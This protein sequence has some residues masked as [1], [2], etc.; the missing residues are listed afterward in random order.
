MLLQAAQLLLLQAILQLQLM[1][2]GGHFHY[3]ALGS[4]HYC[5]A[6]TGLKQENVMFSSNYE[7]VKAN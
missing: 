3:D 4:F 2:Q 7:V 5:V 6:L 1:S